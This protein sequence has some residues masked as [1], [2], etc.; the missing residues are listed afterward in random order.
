MCDKLI[1][2]LNE[3][4]ARR[5]ARISDLQDS[6]RPL[7]E[8]ANLGWDKF[9]IEEQRRI[10]AEERCSGLSSENISLKH[11]LATYKNQKIDQD[12]LEEELAKANKEVRRLQK[13][14][15]IRLGSEAPFGVSTPSSK[16]P[17]K[18]NSTEENQAKRGGAVVGHE[19]HGRKNFTP[20]DAD[21]EICLEDEPERCECGCEQWARKQAD[22][23]AQSV[24]HFIPSR[25]ENRIY[26]KYM[27]EC[28]ECGK[29]AVTNT[30]GVFSRSLH[31]N[32]MIAHVLTE[33]YLWGNTAGTVAERNEINIGTFFDI[34]HRTATQ[35]KPIFENIALEI[36][37]SLYIHADETGW[38]ND[39]ASGYA[40]LFT[41]DDFKLFACRQ[42]RGSK[43]PLGIFGDEKQSFILIT[44]RYAGYNKIKAKRQFC[45]VHLIR[46]VIKLREEFP[47][48][49]EVKC[50]CDILKDLLKEAIAL[51]AKDIS[52][53][54]YKSEAENI[55]NKIMDVCLREARDPGIQHIQN[56]FRESTGNLFHWVLSPE[57]PA[58]NNFAER[59]LRPLVIARK[60][61][62][63]SQSEQG[64]E[65]REILMSIL[66]TAKCR[67]IDPASFLEQILDILA[68][69]KD[70][71]IS[72][73]LSIKHKCSQKSVA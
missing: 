63:G 33:S 58:E 39:G 70:A 44:D 66:N 47:E 38:K 19:G 56:I 7:E 16:V 51:R 26:Y 25:I 72:Q 48:D 57:I 73:M 35:L 28:L 64:L 14:L 27:H 3:K 29:S 23:I 8:Y 30:P 4:I 45:Y 17:Y 2:V 40:W 50:F 53:D 18:E 9:K 24:R 49:M 60:I 65:T 42:S 37:D 43:V 55:K 32:S 36:C 21:S 1:N 11:E 59:G 22:P 67:D 69:D 5:D 6:I 13:Q 31:S 61:S 52:L 62:F 10:I 34:A 54:V 41:N 71:D 68:K 15:N 20:E 46:D 12:E